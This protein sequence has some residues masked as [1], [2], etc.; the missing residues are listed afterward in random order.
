M[1]RG[2]SLGEGFLEDEIVTCPLHGWRYNVKTGAN[3][4]IPNQK[5]ASYKVKVEGNDVLVALE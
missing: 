1:H 2:G 3:L 5:I 4:M